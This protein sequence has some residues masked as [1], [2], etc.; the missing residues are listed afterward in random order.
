MQLSTH[1]ARLAR[2]PRAF[3]MLVVGTFVNRT[4][5]VV[6][7]FLPLFLTSERGLS[8]PLATAAV[9]VYGTGAFLGG[10]VGGWLSD[11]IGRRAVLLASLGGG[12]V[13]LGMI[14]LAPSTALIM[15]ATLAFGFLGEM[16]RPAVT[17]AVAD[18]IDEADRAEA[19]AILYWS[20]N[21]GVAVGP[22]LGGLIASWSYLGLFVLDGATLFVYALVVWLAVPETRPADAAGSQPVPVRWAAFG[23]G[24]LLTVALA[25]LLVGLGFTQL[26]S[27]LPLAMAADGLT[28][29]DFGLV[30][31]VNGG[32]IALVGLPVAAWAGRR[33]LSWTLP[34]SV[35]LVALGIGLQAYTDTFTLYALAAVVWTVGE[36]AFLPVVPNIVSRLA[37]IH[38][39][40]SYQGVYH[41]G[42]GMAKMI[43]PAA[44]GVVLAS[45]GAGTLWFVSEGTVG[46]AAVALAALMPALRRRL[47]VRSDPTRS[48]APA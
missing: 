24:V 30:V 26:F 44:G 40:G 16:Y 28:E 46:L 1:R 3:W 35:A 29:L 48:G 17:A 36:M 37:P 34:A 23:D 27:A 10:F 33:M 2:Y 42:W 5:M 7:P 41:A 22:A 39:R 13:L 45:A 11:R 14:P 47:S 38:L 9:S 43:G 21:L 19:F 25:T 32:L 6:L 15:A 12:A 20:I 8:I 31:S 4:G 18:L